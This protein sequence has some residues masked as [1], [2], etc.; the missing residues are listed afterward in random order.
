MGIFI[1]RVLFFVLFL[2]IVLY[3]LF[4]ARHAI[5]R[6]CARVETLVTSY[7][8]V[9]EPEEGEERPIVRDRGGNFEMVV[10]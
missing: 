2:P 1:F 7:R 10:L 4:L 9:E 8:R 6:G 3:C 5:A